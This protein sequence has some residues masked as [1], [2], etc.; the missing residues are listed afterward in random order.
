MLLECDC[1][2]QCSL[3]TVSSAST[4]DSAKST[5]RITCGLTIVRQVVE[6]ALDCKRSTELVY[7]ATLGARELER[8]RNNS[9]RVGKPR[10]HYCFFSSI[11]QI[12][13]CLSPIVK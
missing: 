5:H 9:R 13:L 11:V 6:P 4:H 7:N 8:W 10:A 2:K 12:L 1:S 3:E